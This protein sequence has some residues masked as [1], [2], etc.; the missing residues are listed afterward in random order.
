MVIRTT[1]PDHVEQVLA[2]IGIGEEYAGDVGHE[3]FHVTL[4]P[5]CAPDGCAVALGVE[6]AIWVSLR[7]GGRFESCPA[8]GVAT[9]SRLASG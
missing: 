8:W 9:E 2:V 1:L 4:T 5:K 7:R 3:W 6:V